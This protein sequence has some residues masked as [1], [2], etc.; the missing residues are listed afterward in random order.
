MSEPPFDDT[1]GTVRRMPGTDWIEVLLDD[2]TRV[3]M[4]SLHPEDAQVFFEVGDRVRLRSYDGGTL[5]GTVEKLNP[6]R[7][8]VRCG[9]DRWAVPYAGLDHLCVS[10]A[11]ER[12]SHATRLREV[13]A[14]ARELMDRHGLGEWTLRFSGARRKLGECRSR[15]KLILLSRAHAVNGSP[16]QVTDTILHEIAHA[17]ADPDAGHGPAWK[18]IARKLGATPKSCLPE[19]D[20]TRQRREAAKRKF[21]TGDSVSF[22][23]RGELRTGK[24]VRMNPKRAKVKCG[25]AVWSVPYSR[26]SAAL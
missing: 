16:E 18:A 4:D 9:A 19:S 12:R 10:T 13:A 11:T 3:V 17:L 22:T 24:I 7:A 15:Q 1:P 21:R 25:D 6:K 26:L 8:T 5:D 2:A 20:E 23:A 14:R